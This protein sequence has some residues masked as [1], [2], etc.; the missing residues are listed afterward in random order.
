MSPDARRA[1]PEL[2]H[3]PRGTEPSEAV[4]FA[5]NEI[6]I[7]ASPW[8]AWDRLI[9]AERWPRWYLNARRVAVDTSSGLLHEGATFRW[10]TFGTAVR[11]EVVLF[12]PP[13]HLGWLW[14]CEGAYG[15]HGWL[16]EED[17]VG[18]RVITEET[19]FGRRAQRLAGLLRPVLWT[20]H[21]H[22]L[23]R[24]SREARID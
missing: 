4:V 9:Q 15:Y 3:W 6:V 13:T 2:A 5:H 18:T 11:S 22:W 21:Q 14:W 20:A 24:L 19:Q 10:R 7:P 12:V 8:R 23:R 16:F 1:G 17:P